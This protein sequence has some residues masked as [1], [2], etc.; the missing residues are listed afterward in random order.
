MSQ[1]EFHNTT[2]L[3]SQTL[4]RLCNECIEGWNVGSILLRIRDS[5]GADFSGTC[6][7]D[8]RKIYI[9]IG[10]HLVYPYAMNTHLACAVTIGRRWFK[11]IYVINIENGIQLAMFIFMHELY[12]LLVRRARRNPRQKESRC[13]RFA[14]RYLVDRFGVTVVTSKGKPVAREQ[15]DF[16]DVN[17]FVAVTRRKTRAARRP[18]PIVKQ[19]TDDPG[20]GEQLRLFRPDVMDTH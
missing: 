15:W 11:P 5:R 7:Y 4:E 10:K 17:G 18:I 9:N 2:T 12:H 1:I 6:F 19:T 13:D 16:Q 3:S 20:M 14:A 8:Q